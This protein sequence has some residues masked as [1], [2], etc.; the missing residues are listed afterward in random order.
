MLPALKAQ[1]AQEAGHQK[2][3]YQREPQDIEKR[4]SKCHHSHKKKN[5]P[6]GAVV[7]MILLMSCGFRSGKVKFDEVADRE[8]Y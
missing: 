2:E 8:T 7:P 5:P 6:G 3:S 4:G 1:D